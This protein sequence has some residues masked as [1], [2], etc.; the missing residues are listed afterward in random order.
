MMIMVF[1]LEVMMVMMIKM[2]IKAMMIMIKVN[3]TIKKNNVVGQCTMPYMQL[4]N[5]EYAAQYSP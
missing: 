2:K 1:F 3:M 5:A 4:D